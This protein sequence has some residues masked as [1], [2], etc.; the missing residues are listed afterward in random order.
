DGAPRRP[1]LRP[2]VVGSSVGERRRPGDRAVPRRGGGGRL[3]QPLPAH[4]RPGV[5]G[6]GERHPVAV[7]R[8]RLP[9]GQGRRDPAVSLARL[10]VRPA[11][12]RA[13]GRRLDCGAAGLP[14]GGG[15]RRGLSAPASRPRRAR[16]APL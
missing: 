16:N 4:G 5:P 7:R 13:P 6:G 15:R 8:L 10:G 1:G 11:H 12:W 14:G 3:A 9:A 2:S